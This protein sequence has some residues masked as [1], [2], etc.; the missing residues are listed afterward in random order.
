MA[1]SLAQAWRNA[2]RV[3][4]AGTRLCKKPR[5]SVLPVIVFNRWQ[6]GRIKGIVDRID[7]RLCNSGFPTHGDGSAAGSHSGSPAGSILRWISALRFNRAQ[8]E[9]EK[10]SEVVTSPSPVRCR[11][12]KRRF[13]RL[14]APLEE[15]PLDMMFGDESSDNFCD[16]R[17]ALAR[18]R[19]DCCRHR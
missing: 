19:Q 10:A 16:G 12:G 8:R 18:L 5:M 3:N 1:G 4:S 14:P 15:G 2:A 17:A 13:R 7:P 11:A 9:D 6:T